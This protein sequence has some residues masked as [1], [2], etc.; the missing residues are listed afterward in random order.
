MKAVAY[1]QPGAIESAD[2]LVDTELPDPGE[3]EGHDLLVAVHA[4]AVN[5]IDTKVRAG[6]APQAGT[7]DEAKVLGWDAAGTVRA[8]GPEV[9]RFQPGDAVWYAGDITRPGSNAEL[10]LV[11]ER[12]VGHKPQSLD[13]REAAALPLTTITAW[14]LLFERLGVPAGKAATD[15]RLL[16]VGGAGGVGSVLI[17]L[18]ARLTGLTVIATASRPETSEWARALG[19]HGVIDHRRP[20]SE[21]LQEAGMDS[22]SHVASLTHTDAHLDEL[23]ACLAP[24][25]RLALIDDPGEL[26][27]RKLKPKSL[28]LHWE[29][30]FTRSLF[31]TADVAAQHRLLE[32]AAALVDAGVLRTTLAEDYGPVNAANLIRA[33]KLLESGRSRGKIVLTGFADD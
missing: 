33:H 1:Y 9:T 16:V 18:A 13:F 3:P 7:P 2:A 31:Q 14:E 5:P 24:Q 32:E 15:D 10:Q 28:S 26:D 25:G 11:D 22:V 17:Q 4:V 21:A 20:L 6:T 30:M 12:I 27:V 8:V 19:A 29:L 23:V